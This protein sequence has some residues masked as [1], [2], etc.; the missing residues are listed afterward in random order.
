MQRVVNGVA[1]DAILEHV[2]SDI[3][4]NIEGAELKDSFIKELR[5]T[6]VNETQ[7]QILASG[8]QYH[9]WYRYK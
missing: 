1:E 8:E 7:S 5:H 4:L 6:L 3:L 9:Y 2:I